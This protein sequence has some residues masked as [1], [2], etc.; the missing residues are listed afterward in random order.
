MNPLNQGDLLNIEYEA[1]FSTVML[2]FLVKVNGKEDEVFVKTFVAADDLPCLAVE[3]RERLVYCMR[4]A[5][6]GF[7][8]RGI[9]CCCEYVISL[10]TPLASSLS[11]CSS[12]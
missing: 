11:L 1:L 6:T 5:D 10:L 8:S 7:P 12:K 3:I 9:H 4:H 2:V